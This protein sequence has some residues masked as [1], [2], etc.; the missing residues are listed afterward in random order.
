[1]NGDVK[2]IQGKF[3]YEQNG[4]WL[5]LNIRS[6]AGGGGLSRSTVISLI[7]QYGLT[8]VT[9]DGSLSGNGTTASP[10]K[11]PYKVY[12][13]LLTQAGTAA[14]V[15]TILENTLGGVPTWVRN[16]PGLYQANLTGVFVNGKT[17]VIT[18]SYM[19]GSAQDVPISYKP[20]GNNSVRVETYNSGLFGIDNALNG[21]QIEIRVYP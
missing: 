17:W 14:P 7:N 12:V 13:A 19:G 6:A 2:Y 1:M 3:Y 11:L 9:T 8:S 15:A 20:S 21:G 4:L 10:L 16:N 18:N 5:P